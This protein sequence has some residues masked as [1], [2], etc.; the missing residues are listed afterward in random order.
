MTRS[1]YIRF[2]SLKV[3][4]YCAAVASFLTY[5]CESW[6]LI[7]AVMHNLNDCNSQILNTVTGNNVQIET[8]L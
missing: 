5:E 7:Q 3:R 1:A 4:L 6:N 8:T 2:S